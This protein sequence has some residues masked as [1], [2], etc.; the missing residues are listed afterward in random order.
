MLADN[1]ASDVRYILMRVQK[2]AVMKTIVVVGKH[3]TIL[4]LMAVFEV[5]DDGRTSRT[6]L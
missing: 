4:E 3:T 5:Y 1:I 2:R 6:F